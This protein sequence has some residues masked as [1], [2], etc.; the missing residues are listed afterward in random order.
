ML[1]MMDVES[2]IE[3]RETSE[4]VLGSHCSQ[5]AWFGKCKRWVDDTQDPTGLF[6]VGKQKFGLKDVGLK[7]I[8]DISRMDVADY[9]LPPNKIPRMGEKSLARMKRRALVMLSGEPQ[10]RPGY[11]F[12]DATNEIYFDI[13]DDPTRDVTYL[14]GMWIRQA[15]GKGKFE[16]ILADRPEDEE[17][18]CRRF[19]DFVAAQNDEVYY[20]YSHKERSSLRRLME[21][22]KLSEEVFDKY[23]AR[24]FDQYQDLIVEFSDWPTYSYGIKQ[25]AKQVGFKWRDTEPGG[26]NSIAWYNE[27]LEL[28]AA[29]SQKVLTRILQYNEDDCIAMAHIKD[30]FEERR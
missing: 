11:V 3:A 9:L 22:Y 1:A 7:T 30:W 20:V 14:F 13:E 24:E 21:K 5:C 18:A 28:E 6:F 19:W 10:I 25:I 27:Y 15:G 8:D 23:V 26:A 12:P 2:L 29:E 16:Y 4:P 17:D